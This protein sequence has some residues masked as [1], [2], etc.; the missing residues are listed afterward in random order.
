MAAALNVTLSFGPMLIG[1]YLNMILYGILLNQMYFYFQT[2]KTDALWIR[3]L[4][5]YLFVMETANTILDM[6]MMYQPLI[7]E[8]GTEK[9]VAN[10]PILFMTE[11]IVIVLISAPIQCFFAWRINKITKSYYVPIIIIVL[12]LASTVGGVITGVKIAIL[13]LFSRKPE[14]H[15]SALLWFIPSCVADLLITFTLVLSLSKRKTGFGATD[16]AIDKLIRMTVQTGMITAICAIGDVAFFM[17]LPHTALNFLWD[18][19]LS[20]LYT[21]CLMSNLN[22]RSRI[23]NSSRD[24]SSGIGGGGAYYRNGMDPMSPTRGE[25][26][27]RHVISAPEVYELESA[28]TFEAVS[29][30]SHGSMFHG[31]D[32]FGIT[33]TK[34]VE[35]MEDP[36][37]ET[38]NSTTG[39][40]Q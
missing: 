36:I 13:K 6:A 18:L 26:G 27:I 23:L 37:H 34:V 12:A 31:T 8:Y 5:A 33:V 7:T 19:S 1:V 38:L 15:W 28:K 10:F 2:Y 9:A 21:N 22:A 20:K 30:Q 35:R 17:A 40:A 29:A 39:I 14:L 16:S 25:S 24:A 32:G 4:A 11:P 3:L